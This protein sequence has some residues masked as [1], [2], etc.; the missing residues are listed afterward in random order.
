MKNVM[1]E[2]ATWANCLPYW[3]QA[4]LDK[5]LNR[6]KFTE[7][8]YNEL[9]QLFLED[10]QLVEK[11]LSRQILTF[12]QDYYNRLDS[13]KPILLTEISNLKNVNALVSDQRLIFSPQLTAIFGRN[14]SGKSGY[15]RVLGC[16]G[17][18]RG[19]KK[20][21]PDVTKP[22]VENCDITA[23]ITLNIDGDSKTIQYLVK[24]PCNEL[25]SFYIFDST[26]VQV[27][28]KGRNSFSFSPSGLSILTELARATDEV[29]NQLRNKIAEKEQPSDIRKYFSGE[30][31]ITDLIEE[32]SP[33]TDL[34]QLRALA[35]LSADEEKR[36]HELNIEIGKIGLEKM[37]E[38]IE[39]KE[40][41]LAQSQK[42][43]DW[44]RKAQELF[45]DQAIAEI[46][47]RVIKYHALEEKARQLSIER[48]QHPGLSNVGSKLWHDFVQVAHQLAQAESKVHPYPKPGDPCLLCQQSLS[49]DAHRLILDLWEYLVGDVQK[50]IQQSRSYFS[51]KHSEIWKTNPFNLNEDL[52]KGIELLYTVNSQLPKQIQNIVDNYRQRG[53][54]VETALLIKKPPR[55][56]FFVTEDCI[57]TIQRLIK[58]FEIELVEA[59]QV[60]LNKKRIFLEEERRLLEHRKKLGELMSSIE[61]YVNGRIWADDASKVI[62]STRHITVKY[63][64]LFNSLVRNRYIEI[65]KKILEDLG[66][67]LQVEISTFGSKGETLKQVV[68]K[69]HNTAKEIA[70]PEKVLSEGEKRAVALA[71]F[72]TEVALD[73]TSSGIILDDP[74]TSLDLEWRK[75]ISQLIA[76][77]STKR[78]VIVFTH[79]MAFLYLL[80]NCAE[81]LE[82]DRQVHWIKRGGKD[83]KPGYVWLNNC[84]ALESEYK[85]PTRAE[86]RYK[87]AI[88]EQEPQRQ[89]QILKDGFGALRSTYE[90]FIVYE[91]FNG[92]VLRFDERISFGRLESISWDPSIVKEIVRKCEWLSRLI[93]GHL[94]S[95]ALNTIEE[96]TPKML[97][98]EIDKFYDLKK[99]LQALKKN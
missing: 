65:F 58:K 18:T 39:Q 51:N 81:E 54:E 6:K 28:M 34:E 73:T 79:D 68:L 8:D 64:Q 3:E 22:L 89:E 24:G 9:L 76:N 30:S 70:D 36:I 82:I 48:F 77:E 59:K 46:E 93:E 42:L 29:R 27:H 86:E 21:V 96:L 57:E 13:R 20:V 26:S 1:T 52:S 40:E 55:K 91:L 67:P 23:E 4:A 97:R 98:S 31:E 99:R 80:L 62:G 50:E 41:Q 66:R 61:T 84:P 10:A 33:D 90:A 63:N 32:L 88:N 19:D 11:T 2:I 94:H 12:Q 25:S 43:Y 7:E 56:V 49:R 75:T 38:D 60:D 16:A 44:L 35:Q 17:F 72:L 14:G 5:V 95:D 92:V 74:V 71:D 47:D 15:A 53:R 87:E 45:N 83:N 37:E 85:K 78:Q 69:A